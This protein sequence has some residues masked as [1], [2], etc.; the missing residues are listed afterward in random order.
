MELIQTV[1]RRKRSVARALVTKGSGKITI[2]KKESKLY[3]PSMVLHS[4]V[5]QPLVKLDSLNKYDIDITVNGG[6]TTGQ[7][8]AIRLA[9]ARAMVKIDASPE[10]KKLLRA[11]GMMTRDMRKVERKKPGQKK[12]RKRFQFTK[13]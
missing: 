1:G 7:S 9:I 4:K 5:T 3:F 10:T 13:R 2:N 6:G 12:A 11:D 8:E